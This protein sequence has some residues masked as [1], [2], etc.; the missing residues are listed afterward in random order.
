[1]T[2]M[3]GTQI[4]VTATET[5]AVEDPGKGHMTDTMT[6]GAAKAAGLR[7]PPPTGKTGGLD[8]LPQAGLQHQPLVGEAGHHQGHTAGQ[9]PPLQDHRAEGE[10]L[11]EE[12]PPDQ[13][14]IPLYHL[15][16][17]LALTAPTVCVVQHRA[18]QNL[19]Q[20]KSLIKEKRSDNGHELL[21]TYDIY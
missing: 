2:T 16:Q 7:Q 18:L 19:A 1:M 3:T 17:D 20:P 9:E 14:L 21:Q 11:P 10:L 12:L 15:R 8:P 5:R 13:E 4:T 6:A